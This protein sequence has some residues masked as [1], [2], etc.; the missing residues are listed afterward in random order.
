MEE[1]DFGRVNQI[2]EKWG[3]DVIG[4]MVAI[5]DAKGSQNLQNNIEHEIL[6]D[7]EFV[8]LVIRMPEYAQWADT[9]RAGGSQILPPLKP[10]SEWMKSRGIPAQAL[11]P[12]AKK[13]AREGTK[14]AAKDFL[15]VFHEKFP[16]IKPL[17]QEEVKV[18]Y[19]NY[20]HRQIS[21]MKD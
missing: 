2:L 5:L 3:A 11:F 15:R 20:F 14:H 19:V 17:I 18:E 1:M 12:I 7:A 8:Q 21:K 10:I 4:E 16:E 13:I 9:G 6:E